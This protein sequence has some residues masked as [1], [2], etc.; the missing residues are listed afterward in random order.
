MLL[1]KHNRPFQFRLLWEYWKKLTVCLSADFGSIKIVFA[2]SCLTNGVSVVSA[3]EKI[4]CLITTLNCVLVNV[5]L[6][7]TTLLQ[8]YWIILSLSLSLS[9]YIY[10]YTY[11]GTLVE[12]PR[13]SH[14]SCEILS[15]SMHHSLKSCLFYPSSQVISFGRPPSWV[16]F[17]EG[18][19]CKS[20]G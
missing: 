11:S 13:M 9:L 6:F 2:M 19:H 10:I 4:E 8:L 15:I 17:I 20:M 1:L 3:P 14:S 12:R 16:A 18:L 5:I 7:R